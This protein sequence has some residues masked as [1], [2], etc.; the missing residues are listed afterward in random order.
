M[1]VVRGNSLLCSSECKFVEGADDC[2]YNNCDFCEI[3][4]HF[5]F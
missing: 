3:V 5:F 4:K 1:Q 2:D